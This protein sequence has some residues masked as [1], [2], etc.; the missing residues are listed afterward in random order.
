MKILKKYIKTPKT[1]NK[2][3]TIKDIKKGNKGRGRIAESKV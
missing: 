1:E 2:P 3:Q